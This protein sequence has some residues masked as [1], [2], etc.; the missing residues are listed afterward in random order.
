[1]NR[2]QLLSQLIANFQNLYRGML[3]KSDSHQDG[4]PFGQK[5]ALLSVSLYGTANVKQIAKTLHITSGAATQHVEALVKEGLVQ[6]AV[7]PHDR[8]NVII[9]VSAKGKVLTRQLEQRRLEMMEELFSDITDQE[10][11]AYNNIMSKV[12]QK[13]NQENKNNV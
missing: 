1:M 13:I 7:D 4:I 8:R 2:Q 10:L 5:A 11:V 3:H 9:T 6:R 12:S